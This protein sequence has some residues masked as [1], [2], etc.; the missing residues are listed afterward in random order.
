[1]PTSLLVLTTSLEAQQKSNPWKSQN[2]SAK[3]LSP[4][5]A[6]PISPVCNGLESARLSVHPRL[7]PGCVHRNA[8][9]QNPRFCRTRRITP[10]NDYYLKRIGFDPQIPAKPAG[11]SCCTQ[12]V[13]FFEAARKVTPPPIPVPSASIRGLFSPFALIRVHLRPKSLSRL[14]V[15][16]RIFPRCVHSNAQ[17]QNPRYC[18]IRRITPTND[19]Y[20]E[21]IGFDP[22]IPAQPAGPVILHPRNSFFR[23]GPESHHPPI[24]VP[25][26]SIRDLFSPFALIRVHSRPN[27]FPLHPTSSF[28][29]ACRKV[30]LYPILFPIRVHSWPTVFLA[31]QK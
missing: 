20:L 8:Q 26:A 2:L 21:R 5:A 4:D 19:Y 11:L 31:V 23:A 7:F 24:P 28:F 13:R 14:S 30:T 16:P 12:G 10:T 6:K 3:D 27:V 1:M 18:R 15:H 17:R 29:R 25:S 9:R 22:Q